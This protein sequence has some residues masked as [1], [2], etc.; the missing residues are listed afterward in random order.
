MATAVY[1]PN[2]A[3]APN[4]PTSTGGEVASYQIAPA[5][6]S[7]LSLD[8][9]TGTIS[10]TPAVASAQTTYTVTASNATAKV[11]TSVIITVHDAMTLTLVAGNITASGS[12]NGTGP[13]AS[14]AAPAGVA[15]DTAGNIYVADA[16][17]ST[18]R[19]ITP[20]GVVSTLAGTPGTTGTADG[21]GP[22]ASF[23]ESRG[24]AVDGAG[25][26]YVTDEE[27][28]IIRKVTSAG[29]VTTLAG[30]PETA[31]GSADGTG[32]AASFSAPTGVAVDGAGN[33]YVADIQNCTIRKI[34]PAGVVTTLAGAAGEL[35]FTD[36]TGPAAR[37]QYPR[38]LAVD[39]AGNIYVADMGNNA[40]RM[41][42]PDGVVTT[43][44]G[45]RQGSADGTGSAASFNGPH[46]VVVDGA[47]N[48][49]VADTYNNSIRMITPGG[50][51]STVVASSLGTL[52]YP[53]TLSDGLALSPVTGAVIFSSG[54]AILQA[55]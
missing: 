23:G 45:G 26:V 39:G 48:I 20:A 9:S 6:P 46:A 1:R 12:A 22:A 28:N 38:G 8:T 21:T 14:F 32:P 49:Y 17:N 44:A 36:G 31:G 34:T 27:Y 3:I 54:N 15:A 33:V 41:V 42:T 55:L 40:I 18:L 19:K 4:I 10:G 35:G 25:N 47:G 43:L 37:F 7:G 52:P 50:V 29:V 51:V 53:I 13:A 5:L 11:T 2:V 24:V 16:T 30:T